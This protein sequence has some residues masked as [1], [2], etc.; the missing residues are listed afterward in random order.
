MTDENSTEPG[1]P[2]RR[3]IVMITENRIDGDSRVQKTAMAT[4][5]AGFDVVL[6]GPS[7]D[8]ERR[9]HDLHGARV[10]LVPQPRGASADFNNRPGRSL[11]WPLAYASHSHSQAKAVHMRSRR[12]LTLERAT[13]L[14]VAQRGG[15]TP[16]LLRVEVLAL[17]VRDKAA[18]RWHKLRLS[19][20]QRAS[21]HRREEPSGLDRLRARTLIRLGGRGRWRALDPTMVD[22]DASHSP[23]V[24]E[25]E[26]DLVHAHDFRMIGI[27]MRAADRRNVSGQPCSVVYDAHEYLPGVRPR[28]LSWQLANIRSEAFYIGRADAVVTVSDTLAH[29]LQDDHRLP[30]LPTVVLNAPS[31]ADTGHVTVPGGVR[32]ACGLADGSPLLVYIGSPAPQ[33][34]LMTVVEALPE[35]AGMHAALVLPPGTPYA[36]PLVERARELDVE[37][38]LHVLPYVPQEEVVSFIR[39]ADVGVIPL[40]HDLNHEISLIT[41]YFDYAHAG[42]PVVVSD[43]RTMAATTR[44]LGNGEVFAAE[45]SHGFAAAVQTVLADPSRYVAAYTPQLLEQWSWEA[46]E[47]SLVEVYERLLGA[48]V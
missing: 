7:P 24:T 43:V 5:A 28:N 3:R 17:K 31:S 29:M 30:T 33:R 25:L 26:P 35:L 16:I 36:V 47:R 38:R 13:D 32:A 39:G 45:D 46:Q 10:I 23:V 20:L 41:K 21:L 9:E 6:V 27:A 22:F 4:A 15:R 8:R 40:H 18:A 12:A 14:R 34:G 2:R 1:A 11:R 42:L 44:E 37:D 48:Q 19:E